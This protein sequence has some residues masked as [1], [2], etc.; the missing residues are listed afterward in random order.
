MVDLAAEVVQ[1]MASSA[2]SRLAAGGVEAAGR[3]ISALRAKLRGDTSARGTLEIALEDQGEDTAAL[4][5]L[6]ALLR[7]RILGDAEFAAW[8]T[9]LWSEIAPD[10]RPEGDRT[11]NI[12][13]GPVH[14]AVIQAGSINGGV[15]IG[16][17][18]DAGVPEDTN[19]EPGDSHTR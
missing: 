11:A 18:S 15:H 6:E 14:G 12:V 17:W 19:R 5:N 1:A 13:H 2:G 7:Q 16:Q 9:A 8:L 4:A 3:L 10:A